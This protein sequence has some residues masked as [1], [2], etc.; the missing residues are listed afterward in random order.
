MPSV[1]TR[2][3][4][5]GGMKVTQPV[6]RRCECSVTMCRVADIDGAWYAVATRSCQHSMPAACSCKQ[7]LCSL[8]FRCAWVKVDGCAGPL[9]LVGQKVDLALVCSPAWLVLPSDRVS[10]DTPMLQISAEAACGC[11]CFACLCSRMQRLSGTGLHLS[12]R[13]LGSDG[14]R[15]PVHFGRSSCCREADGN[16]LACKSVLA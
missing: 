12:T 3:A 6:Q 13:A 16:R 2:A 4:D 9:R 5:P 1:A 11:P 14:L 7:A 15:A 10:V 8:P